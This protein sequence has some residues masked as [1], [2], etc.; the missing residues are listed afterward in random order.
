MLFRSSGE[1]ESTLTPGNTLLALDE[2]RD[3]EDLNVNSRVRADSLQKFSQLLKD[4]YGYEK[5]RYEDWGGDDEMNNKI[6]LKL[7][8]NISRNHKMTL[9][10][11]FSESST[12]FR[13]SSSGDAR[14]SISGGRHSRTG[15]MSFENAQYFNSNKL[16]SVTAE[17]NSRFGQLSNKFLFAYTNYAQPRASNSSVFPFIDIMNGDATRGDVTM[18]AGYELFSYKNRV[19]N[20]TLILTNNLSYQVDKHN[21]TYGL[22]YEHQ[23]FANSYLR[24]GSSYYRFKHLGACENFLN[25]EVAGLP[26]NDNYHPVNFAYTY[27]INGLTEPIAELSFGQF[28]TYLQDEYSMLSNLKIMAGIRIDLPMYLDGALDN[29][30]IHGKTFANGESVDIST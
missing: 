25:G 5:G 21:L 10:Y 24:Q 4:K 7:N 2:G 6:L 19:D 23:Y 22:S 27:P 11:N 15:G 14:P 20:N 28:S 30:S 17:L 26:Y 3:P 13:P 18:S 16:H 9:R 12:V 1:K 29:P 8:W